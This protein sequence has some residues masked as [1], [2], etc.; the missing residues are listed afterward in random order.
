[1]DALSIY[2]GRDWTHG[3]LLTWDADAGTELL[4][5]A[6]AQDVL[7]IDR[8]TGAV[9]EIVG[10]DGTYARPAFVRNHDPSWLDADHLLMFMTEAGQ[11]GAVEYVRA[12]GDFAEDWR[13]A[14][15]TA[16]SALGQAE[17]LGNGDTFVNYG[18][19]NHV[20]EVAPDCTVVWAAELE[21][22]LGGPVFGQFHLVDDL[23][24]GP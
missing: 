14:F 3:N 24:S 9:L 2:P 1:M 20:A 16:P 6:N 19:R 8:A 12:D 21:S 7:T 13:C 17:R 15:D 18:T 23:Y 5:L 22:A 4:S 10:V 11:A